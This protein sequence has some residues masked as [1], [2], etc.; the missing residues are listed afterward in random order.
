VRTEKEAR[1]FDLGSSW[2]AV[3][4]VKDDLAILSHPL[5]TLLTE[6]P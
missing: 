3:T 2:E 5:H 6:E 4:D 1:E